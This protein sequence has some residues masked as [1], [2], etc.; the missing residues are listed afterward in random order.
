MKISL[1]WLND[2][3][4]LK[5][6]PLNEII[7]K[8]SLAG[9][10]VEEVIDQSKNFENIVV[11]YVKEK[12]KHPNADK[13]SVCIVSDGLQ[14]YNVVCGAPNVE[15][16]QKVPFA[17]V[18]AV[19]PFNGLKLEIVKIRG[20]ISYGMI[21]SE[22]ELGLSDNHEGIMVLNSE[23]KEGTLFADAVGIND[24]ILDIAITPNRADAL[25]HIGV[26]RDLSAIFDRPLKI[27]PVEIHESN[28]KSE[29]VAS[30]EIVDEI[31]CPRYVGKVV[32]N[33]QIKES[34][35]WLQR[36]LKS[37]GLRPINNVV[38]VTNYVL[39]EVG[40]PLHAFDLD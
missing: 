21:C 2:Y 35:E 31:N 5:D 23:L 15:A 24:V 29:D 40:Q 19:I 25:S 14:D 33:V 37:V 34:P 30:V 28:I 12:R 11:G 6:I 27:P 13:L 22:K 3:I 16:G 4:D 38:D 36:R 7:E 17:K 10:E 18:G 32:L 8:L 39:Y 20:E 9:L 1:N 26:A